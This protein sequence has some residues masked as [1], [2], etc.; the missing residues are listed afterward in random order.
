M[1]SGNFLHKYSL[2]FWTHY[3]MQNPFTYMRTL[4]LVCVNCVGLTI[5][6]LLT[7]P[8]VCSL[9]QLSLSDDIHT[10]YKLTSLKN[11]NHFQS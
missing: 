9:T 5:I 4:S 2:S 10:T 6:N 1:P 3:I 7:L 8:L 11:K